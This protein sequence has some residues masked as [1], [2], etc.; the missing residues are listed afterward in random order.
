[1]PER[2]GI[3]HKGGLA[4]YVQKRY[5]SWKIPAASSA[6]FFISAAKAIL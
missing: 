1:L 5:E 3:G 4:E 2:D 6:I